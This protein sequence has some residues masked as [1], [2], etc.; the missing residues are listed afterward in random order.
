MVNVGV[1]VKLLVDE[2]DVILGNDLVGGIYRDPSCTNKTNHAVLV[3]GYG[4]RAGQAFW[5][6]KNSWATTYGEKGYVRMAR[7]QNNMC[8]I[9]SRAIYP[10]M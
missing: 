4:G 10:V 1:C 5:L 9:A 8:G 3:V 7:N 2:V 6:V